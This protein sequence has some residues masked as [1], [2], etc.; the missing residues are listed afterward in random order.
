MLTLEQFLAEIG[1]AGVTASR[2]AA[3]H[4][5]ASFRGYFDAD[6]K[7]LTVKL[8]INGAA[9]EVPVVCLMPAT[10]MTLKKIRVKFESEVDLSQVKPAKGEAEGNPH[11]GLRLTRGLFKRGTSVEVDA[12]FRQTQE[13]EAVEKIRDRLNTILW[14]ALNVT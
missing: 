13:P 8:Q 5:Q 14:R 11:I 4:A 3:E 12:L 1:R 9:V 10:A 6:G 7:P 2:E